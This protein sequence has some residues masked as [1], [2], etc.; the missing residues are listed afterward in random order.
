MTNTNDSKKDLILKTARE[1]LAQNGFAKTTLDDIA[2]ALGMKKSSLYYYYENKDDLIQ[3]VMIKEEEKFFTEVYKDLSKQIPA[4][5]K[6]IKFELAKF[7]YVAETSKMY[8]MTPNLFIDFKTKLFEY[9]KQV[10]AK[11]LNILTEIITKGIEDKE[12]IKCDSKK[13]ANLL[14]TIS[15][16]LRHREFYYAAFSVTK[17]INFDNAVE[18][19]T[20]AIKMIFEGLKTKKL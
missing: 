4:I 15:E 3:D 10:R 7:K 9:L 12:I 5:D 14:L 1:L 18:E 8:I 20:F 11:E 17:E 6:I 16:S 2:G 19:M 13:V